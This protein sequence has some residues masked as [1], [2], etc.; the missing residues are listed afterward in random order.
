MLI[1]E[2]PRRPYICA[3]LS[4]LRQVWFIGDGNMGVS[5]VG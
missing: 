1:Q 5:H 4:T 2:V 3:T